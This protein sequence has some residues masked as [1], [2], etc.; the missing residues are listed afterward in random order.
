MRK[1]KLYLWVLFLVFIMLNPLFLLYAKQ[2]PVDNLTILN[3]MA[4]TVVQKVID[5]LSPDSSASVLIHS[6][7]L[8]HIGNWWLENWFV[9]NLSQQGLSKI[10]INQMDSSTMLVVEFQIL[11]L[12]VKYLSTDKKKLVERR[13]NLSLAVRTFERSSGLIRF[14]DKIREEYADSIQ[15]KDVSRLE[16]RDYDFTQANLPEKKGLKKLIEPLIVITTT[17][18]IIYLFFCLRSN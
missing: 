17:A 15:I 5:K 10:Y 18:G 7:S 8:Q 9:K 1:R 12:G 16:N 4:S 13:F 14:V 3:N 11:D 2:H 6:Q